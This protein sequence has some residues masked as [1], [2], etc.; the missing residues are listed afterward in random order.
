VPKFEAISIQNL[1]IHSSDLNSKSGDVP[2]LVDRTML[3]TCGIYVV[4][5]H[6]PK[7]KLA[8][9]WP[10]NPS[11]YIGIRMDR[12]HGISGFSIASVLCFKPG[13]NELLSM[14]NWMY[15]YPG[16]DAL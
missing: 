2:W 1:A 8:S 11:T 6:S 14:K 10:P 9:L 4:F 16:S 7:R 5:S 13:I 12:S 15:F 3:T